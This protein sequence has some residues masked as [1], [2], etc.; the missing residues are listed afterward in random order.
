MSLI[1]IITGWKNY[2]T[3]DDVAKE[4]AIERSKKCAGCKHAVPSGVIFQSMGDTI[5]EIQGFK[6]DLCDCPLSTKL[7]AP[8]AKCDAGLWQTQHNEN[9]E[10]H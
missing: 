7:R 1:D 9:S 3:D 6:C 2:L 10:P 8:D 5:K 4:I